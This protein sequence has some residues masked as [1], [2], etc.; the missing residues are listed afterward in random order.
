MEFFNDIMRFLYKAIVYPLKFIFF[1]IIYFIEKNLINVNLSDICEECYEKVTLPYYVCPD[2]NN[3]YA[4]LMPTFKHIFY[5]KCSCGNNLPLTAING[6]NK[7][8]TLCGN[9]K[10]GVKMNKVKKICIPIIGTNSSIKANF[11]YNML[12][13]IEWKF[14]KSPFKA[15]VSTPKAQKFFLGKNKKKPLRQIYIFNTN[16]SDL[17]L[18]DNLKKYRYFNYYD[19]IV[20]IFSGEE[21]V[22][23]EGENNLTLDG[24]LD[25]FIL[26]LQKNFGLK[27]GEIID[28]PIAFI[29][30][31]QIK[32]KFNGYIEENF[33]AKIENNFSDYRFFLLD[34]FNSIKQ[35]EN[36]SNYHEAEVF[37]WILGQV[38]T[39][40]HKS[41]CK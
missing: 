14:D 31:N 39:K 19:G 12:D 1:K 3:R 20:F 37:Q 36:K 34:D 38:D 35:S 8:K 32:S 4:A 2:C 15:Y 18:S 13:T 27:P 41:I 25:I 11:T 22:N 24:I 33:K 40:I 28:K 6:K 16:E 5:F 29:T 21:L 17:A 23:L 26:N 30:N 10:N 7:L 9:C